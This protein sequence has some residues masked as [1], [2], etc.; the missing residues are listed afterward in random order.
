VSSPFER[1]IIWLNSLNI[2]CLTLRLTSAS[3]FARFSPS[4][5]HGFTANFEGTGLSVTFFSILDSF[6][7]SDPSF[8]TLTYIL[9]PRTSNDSMSDLCPY[10]L[11]GLRLFAS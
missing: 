4:K 8:R 5:I 6:G 3:N 7:R 2:T 1:L 10:C 11:L 9:L